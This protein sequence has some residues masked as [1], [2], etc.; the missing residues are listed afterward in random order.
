MAQFSGL[1]RAIL[2]SISALSGDTYRDVAGEELKTELTQRGFSPDDSALNGAMRALKAGGFVECHFTWGDDI[3]LIHLD[4]AGRQEVEGWPAVPG[5]VSASDVE[6]FVSALQARG[7]DADVP[8]AERGR[9]RAAASALRDLS[10]DVTAQ[11]FAA[12]LK[13]MGVG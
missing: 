4:L 10:V 3:H 13:Q 11:V 2:L 7:D 9:A 6:A 5:S 12:W 8:E 1:P